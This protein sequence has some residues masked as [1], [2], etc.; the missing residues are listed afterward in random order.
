MFVFRLL[1][2]FLILPLLLVTASYA[3]SVGGRFWLLF[4]VWPLGLMAFAVIQF[5]RDRRDAASR[6]ELRAAGD[7]PPRVGRGGHR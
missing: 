5:L 4:V 7:A 6:G 1:L 2:I 3:L